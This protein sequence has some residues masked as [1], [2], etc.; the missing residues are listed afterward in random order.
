[1]K[2]ALFPEKPAQ[3]KTNK[4]A[5]KRTQK[6][7]QRQNKQKQLKCLCVPFLFT[8]LLTMCK[9][10]SNDDNSDISN[11]Q[12]IVEHQ[13]TM[14]S[15]QSRNLLSTDSNSSRSYEETESIDFDF[16]VWILGSVLCFLAAIC[17]LL[18]RFAISV[19]IEKL[20]RY[21]VLTV[22][23]IRCYILQ[24]ISVVFG[25]F[26]YLIS[27][28]C[29]AMIKNWP[30]FAAWFFQA[31]ILLV[32][33]LYASVFFYKI[34]R[35]ELEGSSNG[36]NITT[37]T[38]YY[39]EEGLLDENDGVDDDDDDFDGTETDLEQLTPEE[40]VTT[41][42]EGEKLSKFK[43]NKQNGKEQR[44]IRLKI[45]KNSRNG[46][47]QELKAVGADDRNILED[48]KT[49][50]SNF[51]TSKAPNGSK[52]FKIP[53]TEHTKRENAD[54][55]LG[56]KVP[57]KEAVLIDLDQEEV[58]ESR[59]EKGPVARPPREII[60]LSPEASEEGSDMDMCDSKYSDGRSSLNEDFYQFEKALEPINI[61]TSL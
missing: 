43:T 33:S 55:D 38:S 58:E 52:S 2:S 1:M 32:F 57:V 28:G 41:W 8:F 19:Q 22:N 51:K 56:T 11:N 31:T 18:A 60:R 45:L 34:Y 13:K 30:H 10:F 61:Q 16:Q 12:N 9:T 29:L 15:Y 3:T 21:R 14:M 23:D 49:F 42:M 36:S 5:S 39:E 35:R 6:T 40:K 25:S 27:I 54:Y 59:H 50:P 37:S 7:S 24:H 47:R 4:N 20:I 46:Q 53:K 48:S 17:D 26:S 44:K